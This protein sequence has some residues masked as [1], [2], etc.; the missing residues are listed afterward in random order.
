MSVEEDMSASQICG[1]KYVTVEADRSVLKALLQTGL[2]L[3]FI[4]VTVEEDRS[5]SQILCDC[6]RRIYAADR[7]P[8]QN[9][10]CKYVTVEADGPF[11]L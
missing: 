7:P 4:Y 11:P 6:S 9:H 1:C 5:A 8:S 10:E 2:L 3:K